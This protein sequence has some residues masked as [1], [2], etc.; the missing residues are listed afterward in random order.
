MMDERDAGYGAVDEKEDEPL[1]IK[2]RRTL[3][4]ES[5]S[6]GIKNVLQT[7]LHKHNET[8]PRMFEGR[9]FI[10]GEENKIGQGAYGDVYK[11]EVDGIEY[12][13][14][15]VGSAELAEMR[16]AHISY[17]ISSVREGAVVQTL[18]YFIQDDDLYLVME[19][20]DMD[21]KKYL[22]VTPDITIQNRFKILT[23]AAYSIYSLCN[24]FVHRDIAARNFLVNVEN[25]I[26]TKCSVCDFGYLLPLRVGDEFQEVECYETKL[27]FWIMA[28]ETI[29]KREIEIEVEKHGEKKKKI[30][31]IR[32]ASTAGDV[33][34]F[35][36]F[37]M[38]V[39]L[40][41]SPWIAL[42][43]T[44]GW[45]NEVYFDNV[46]EPMKWLN[47]PGGMPDEIWALVVRCLD[48]DPSRR[49][50]MEDIF[51]ILREEAKKYEE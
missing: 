14:K 47:Q 15:D 1:E 2:V 12:V 5:I 39:F 30:K 22:K 20:M 9:T 36:L 27:P 42:K 6:E 45:T 37:M 43:E 40:G 46:K 29:E 35:G 8:P 23:M 49:P 7:P 17:L 32:F 21:V 18:G 31:K 4:D 33:W 50:S 41:V 11:L 3:Q 13:F 25:G 34:Q 16:E 48:L 26:V 38:E 10:F 44:N 51:D 24:R 28:P 19:K